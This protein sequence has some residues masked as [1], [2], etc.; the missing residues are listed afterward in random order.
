MDL[1]VL[2]ALLLDP[3]LTVTEAER[4]AL[5]SPAPRPDP[6]PRRRPADR[7]DRQPDRPTPAAEF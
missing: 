3:C 6:R 2:T 4:E 1:D 5:A 7:P